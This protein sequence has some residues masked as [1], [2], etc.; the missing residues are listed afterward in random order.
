MFTHTHTHMCYSR[1][2]PDA[3]EDRME[4]LGQEV[5]RA[6]WPDILCLQVLCV[7]LLCVL[8]VSCIASGHLQ[9]KLSRTCTLKYCS[10][11]R[12]LH[13]LPTHIHTYN[14]SHTLMLHLISSQEVTPEIL[15]LLAT[16]AWVRRYTMMPL[17]NPPTVSLFLFSSRKRVLLGL[18]M[19]CCTLLR[20]LSMLNVYQGSFICTCKS[21]HMLR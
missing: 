16:A 3:L 20:L 5:E 21:T 19:C 15:H 13:T 7:C 17:P 12:M 9:K 1:F 6:G 8:F 4:G 18:M 10:C 14:S 11:S 2:E